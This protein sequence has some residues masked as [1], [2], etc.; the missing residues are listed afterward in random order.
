MVAQAVINKIKLIIKEG[1]TI[2]EFETSFK[3][4][5]NTYKKHI[6]KI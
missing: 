4:S 6:F 1:F 5:E 2:L 3:L